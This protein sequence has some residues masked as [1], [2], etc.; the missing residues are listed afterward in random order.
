MFYFARLMIKPNMEWYIKGMVYF[1][2]IALMPT[3]IISIFDKFFLKV[4]FDHSVA[5]VNEAI[6]K[7]ANHWKNPIYWICTLI[8]GMSRLVFLPIDILLRF[9][10]G[11]DMF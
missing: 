5:Q 1:W 7:L 10:D 4:L 2:W 11:K 6:P 3:T 8:A 9:I